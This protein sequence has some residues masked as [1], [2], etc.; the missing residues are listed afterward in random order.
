MNGDETMENDTR[1]SIKAR[2]SQSDSEPRFAELSHIPSSA[3]PIDHFLD[4]V[5]SRLLRLPIARTVAS[6]PR[7]AAVSAASR[8]FA[9]TVSSNRV[10]LHAA[11]SAPV[12]FHHCEATPTGASAKSSA[13]VTR[14]GRLLGEV[15]IVTG[16]AA[17]IGRETALLF[18]QEG[19]KGVVVVDKNEKEGKKSQCANKFKHSGQRACRRSREATA[20]Q[21]ARS[22]ALTHRPVDSFLFARFRNCSRRNDHQSR[23]SRSVCRRRRQ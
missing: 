20:L 3:Q 14:P 17:G 12:R 15:C 11:V 2:S 18:A 8:P 22:E 23:R 9:A 10:P 21:D 1:S 16:G 5:M 4:N 7:C 19:A 6:L 13:T